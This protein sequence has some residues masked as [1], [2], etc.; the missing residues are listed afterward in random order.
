MQLLDRAWIH[1]ATLHLMYRF[2][3]CGEVIEALDGFVCSIFYVVMMSW[4]SVQ[5]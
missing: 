2:D 1:V 3:G 5:K 4:M